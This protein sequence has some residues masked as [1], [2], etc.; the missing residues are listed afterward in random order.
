[1]RF[2]FIFILFGFLF[3]GVQ[4][5]KIDVT[6]LENL[7]MRNIGPAGM[8]GRVTSIDVNLSSPENIFIGTASGGVW[9]SNSGGVRWEPIFDEAPLQSIGS[10][11]IN[12]QNPAEIWVGTGE[13]NPRNSQN[14]GEGIFKTI[15]GGKTWKRMG[16]EKT[17]VIHRIIIDPTDSDIVYA[18][19]QGQSWGSN[20][21]RG[22]FKTTDGGQ[23][24]N[25]IL[26]ANENTGIADLVI[27]PSNP[28]KLIAA[29]W[30]FGRKPWTFKSGGPGSGMHITYDGG[31]TWKKLDAK[32][33][34]MPKGELGRIGLSFA[35]SKPNILYALIE[36]KE[37]GLYKSVDGGEKWSLVSKKNI[38]NRPFYYAD[39]FVD[40]GNENR[41]WNLHTY[42]TKSED[43]GKTFKTIL[44]YGKG[45]HP[46]HHAFWQHP[47]DPNF[48]IEGNDGGIN[49][50]R[51]NGVNWRF[52]E[53]IPVA[54]FYHINYD[55][56][57]PYNI[58]GGMQDNGSWVGPSSIWKRGG[59][60]NADWREVMFG[61]G[62]DMVFKQGDSRYLW[63]M[64]QG[65]FL[66]Y[67]DR[68][69]GYT[70]FAKPL[71]PDGIELRFNWNAAIAQNPFDKESIYFG[72]QF[73]H[74]SMD[75]GK[76]WEIISP[77]LTTN[78]STKI[79]LGF[80]TGGLTPDVTRA[81]NHAT[82][83]SILPSP[84]DEDVIWV[85]T[86]D[87]RLQLTK[88]GGENWSDLAS[89]MP[90][91]PSN[92]WIPYIEVS[93][94][95]AGE[96]FIVVNHY[97]QN[98]WKPYLY[99][100]TNYGQSFNRIV[101]PDQVQGHTL[102]V[103]QD[104]I[105]ENLLFL[106]T[107]Y[108]LYFS[109]DKGRNWNKWMKDFPS[110]STRD[111]KIHPRDHD[112]IVG[113]FGRAAWIF[114][115]IEVFRALAKSNGDLLK[116]DF[117]VISST[118][119]YQ[120]NIRSVDG[121]RFTA[122]ANF[123]GDN[124]SANPMI[125]MWVKEKEKKEK[126]EMPTAIEGNKKKKNKKKSKKDEMTK[127]EGADKKMDK[128]KMKKGGSKV[129]INVLD[130][131]GDTLR[132]F[133]RKLKPGMNRLQWG[134][135]RDGILFP[136]WREPQKDADPPGGGADVVPG[137]YKMICTY[138]D[139]KDS[140]MIDVKLDPRL[141]IT[142]SQVA[143]KEVMI[144]EF[145]QTIEVAKEAFDR[146]KEAN[147]TISLVNSQMKNAPDTIQTQIKELG[148]TLQDTIKQ[149]QYMFLAP[150]DAKGIT[151]S[152]DRV[153]SYLST[154]QRYIFN[155]QGQSSQMSDIAKE[156]AQNKLN[157]ALPIIN[158]FFE[159]EWI[160]YQ[161]KVKAARAPLFKKYEPLKLE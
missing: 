11:T 156:Q 98:D 127:E 97:R 12:Q 57:I 152:D 32:E 20:T 116:E 90:G 69:T 106:G 18:G 99:H 140:V 138:N 27:D 124:K 23:T 86:D 145:Y 161:E 137:T 2:S 7:K 31:Q 109:L 142:S 66:G 141:N 114:D 149:M 25:K 24:W 42:V 82:I 135:N 58:G 36:A 108:G 60:R 88:D 120:A 4:A 100:T 14:S 5:Q 50:S 49:I 159:K 157:K 93:Q 17:R 160:D 68:E 89:R 115:D 117:K 19:V 28:N 48:M 139:I 147:K 94:K 107:D 38:G 6:K 123:I 53:N 91:A 104:P 151:R 56:E 96:A 80:K 155:A 39:I 21:E 72:S 153:V 61:D 78:D 77:D 22:V 154:A 52:V 76:S 132:T 111:L 81:E 131:A 51:D 54:Q 92:C 64:S 101:G 158:A 70:H 79:R 43:G 45:V 118:V 29:L 35:P 119:G 46:D 75:S 84:V 148:G 133:S 15:D 3:Q 143:Q 55:M 40:S 146:L 71:H 74:K 1:M 10:L 144:K 136:S 26:Y 85:G 87:G 37:N 33:N 105:E 126:H 8:S 16:L 112:L 128:K 30:E 65:G 113:S 134:M 103:V 129:T 110:V 150:Q 63:S 34:G 47:D 95:N 122:D 73:V 41:L 125:T 130:I 9:H 13:G 102:S 59:I 83:L 62:F 121:V 44:D 67:V